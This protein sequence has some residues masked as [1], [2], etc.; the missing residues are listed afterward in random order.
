MQ[1]YLLDCRRKVEAFEQSL[2]CQILDF[3]VALSAAAKTD[4]CEMGKV[5]SLDDRAEPRILGDMGEEL[6]ENRRVG[7]CD[8]AVERINGG[9]V[10][11]TGRQE[12]ADQ[13]HV[14]RR[15]SRRLGVNGELG[16]DFI[17]KNVRIEVGC[18]RRC[19]SL[20][21]NLDW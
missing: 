17:W 20:T 15:V 19:S 3:G 21:Q 13:I 14:P 5:E 6:G 18:C 12:A 16:N 9:D 7:C 2:G 8:M 4:R 1:Q 11:R 10:Y